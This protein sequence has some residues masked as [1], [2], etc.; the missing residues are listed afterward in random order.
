M[1]AARSSRRQGR[2]QQLTG[3]SGPRARLGDFRSHVYAI[4]PQVGYF[5][6]VGRKKWYLNLKSY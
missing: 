5:L 2:H 3:D 6:P 4:G 1:A